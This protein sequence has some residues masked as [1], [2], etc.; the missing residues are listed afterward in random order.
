MSL[1]Y[2]ALYQLPEESFEPLCRD[3]LEAH[4]GHRFQNFKQ[5]PDGGVDLY[6]E[7]DGIIVQCKH[8]RRSAYSRL[9]ESIRQEAAK[10]AAAAAKRYIIVTSAE[11]SLKN[12]Q[13]LQTIIPAIRSTEDILGAQDIEGILSRNKD[14]ADCYAALW[15]GDK[16]QLMQDIAACLRDV[17]GERLRFEDS[18]FLSLD[19]AWHRWAHI[20]TRPLSHDMFLGAAECHRSTLQAWLQ[21]NTMGLLY[22]DAD[23]EPEALAFL[24]VARELP[25]ASDLRGRALFCREARLLC[26]TWQRTPE[27]IPIIPEDIAAEV[28]PAAPAHSHHL[29]II[30]R[31]QERGD[32]SAGHT[33]TLAPLSVQELF[34]ILRESGLSERE[35]N[36]LLRQK[37]CASRSVLRRRL[38]DIEAIRCPAWARE[39]D[40]LRDLL[41]FALFGGIELGD[42][43]EMSLMQQFTGRGAAE[44][45]R[46]CLT[47]CEHPESPLQC[48][49][50]SV[51]LQVPEEALS[52]VAYELTLPEL[53]QWL[54]LA[55]RILAEA[56]PAATL[57]PDKRLFASIYGK[58]RR[59]STKLRSRIC[60]TL[61]QLRRFG[62]EHASHHSVAAICCHL[63]LTLPIP[64]SMAAI[65]EQLDILPSQARLAPTQL[66]QGFRTIA[67]NEPQEWAETLAEKFEPFSH[68]VTGENIRLSLR[69]LLANK[70]TAFGTADL[71][72]RSLACIHEEKAIAVA[73]S[74][75]CRLLSL[76]EEERITPLPSLVEMLLRLETAHPRE[77]AIML[78]HLFRA[79][80]T[81]AYMQGESAEQRQQGHEVLTLLMPHL[82]H[83]SR[84]EHRVRIMFCE[85]WRFLSA[86]TKQA[87][88][89]M[90]ADE[91][92]LFTE[93]ERKEIRNHLRRIEK[94]GADEQHLLQETLRAVAPKTAEEQA[95]E[96][97][98]HRYGREGLRC[99]CDALSVLT[100]EGGLPALLSFVRKQNDHVAIGHCVGL[101]IAEKRLD[102]AFLL[103]GIRNMQADEI[104]SLYRFFAVIVSQLST[105]EREE[106][107]GQLVENGERDDILHFLLFSPFDAT[108]ARQ[109]KQLRD[110]EQA[111]YLRR[112]RIV[113]IPNADDECAQLIELMLNHGRSW[114]VWEAFSVLKDRMTLPQTMTMLMQ[115]PR[116]TPD[117]PE[118]PREF[119]GELPHIL[120]TL[121]GKADTEMLARLEYIYAPVLHLR[122]PLMNLRRALQQDGESFAE[123]AARVYG[124]QNENAPRP[125]TNFISAV[126]DVIRGEG[127]LPGK[128]DNGDFS[129]AACRDWCQDVRER[130]RRNGA[131][132]DFIDELI[133]ERLAAGCAEQAQ[134]VCPP[135]LSEYLDREASDALLKGFEHR[136]NDLVGTCCGPLEGNLARYQRLK[137][138]YE[139][140]RDNAQQMYIKLPALYQRIVDSLSFHCRSTRISLQRFRKE[141]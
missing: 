95:E 102:K 105:D 103:Q 106:L 22:L 45:E 10:P 82:L 30:R 98:L 1:N 15:M 59:Y 109:R 76:E 141:A 123:L 72:A 17:L 57:P 133:G 118:L 114:T 38:S 83:L 81:S 131:P 88:L 18:C 19:D 20:G 31:R 28:I 93:H 24:A 37:G 135:P 12:K 132:E 60:R 117:T 134:L 16:R 40:F 11:L 34:E 96:A 100:E 115:L 90:I 46:L 66:L 112:Y 49:G 44:T 47:L 97:H 71:L 4:T 69:L 27:L 7:K 52:Y 29:I 122:H 119:A 78:C 75:I 77:T 138:H 13:Q 43:E 140:Q 41:P 110:D 129:M 50:R 125:D 63:H 32:T 9:R 6:A 65:S 108:S 2:S 73:V 80:P 33:I 61:L 94:W 70:I 5:G 85:E 48:I 62:Q 86:E 67:E 56:D 136:I 68:H 121:E 84:K 3:L 101:L 139:T 35:Q 55:G 130:L 14:I 53:E 137:R 64:E 91:A 39:K 36:K 26:A 113:S 89:G 21:D 87:I 54:E 127:L 107:F 92:P 23:S 58:R 74:P 42:S 25:E 104:P 99:L 120:D 126:L 124:Y 128:E 51:S 111:E 116:D 79:L 8:Y